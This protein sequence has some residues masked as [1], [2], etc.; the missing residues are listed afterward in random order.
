MSTTHKQFRMADVI[1]TCMKQRAVTKFLTAEEVGPIEMYRCL[2]IVYGEH[3]VDV[4]TVRCWIMHFKSGET[5]IRDK[6]R[7]G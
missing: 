4:S 3:T 2:N 1:D 7:S 6:S 5:E